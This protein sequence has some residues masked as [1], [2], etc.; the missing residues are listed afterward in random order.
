MGWAYMGKGRGALRGRHEGGKRGRGLGVMAER[1]CGS[2]D[3]QE[4]RGKE[5]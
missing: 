4:V 2:N 5:G 1:P 3:N